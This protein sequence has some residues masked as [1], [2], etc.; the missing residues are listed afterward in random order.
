[1]SNDDAGYFYAPYVILP[2]GKFYD[3]DPSYE[4]F[5]LTDVEALPQ[6]PE[7]ITNNS[8]ESDNVRRD[9]LEDDDL[10]AN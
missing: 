2:T 9:K 8:E 10:S 4:V 1:M 7:S 5:D 6:K 3:C